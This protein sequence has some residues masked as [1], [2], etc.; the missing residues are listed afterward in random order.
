MLGHSV[1]GQKVVEVHSAEG[2]DSEQGYFVSGSAFEGSQAVPEV[3]ECSELVYSEEYCSEGH[4][5]EPAEWPVER[6]SEEHCSVGGLCYEERLRLVEAGEVVSRSA[7]VC[8][9]GERDG[10]KAPR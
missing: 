5:S 10:A 2:W 3:V 7:Q 1:P 9:V 8:S 4:C 6:C